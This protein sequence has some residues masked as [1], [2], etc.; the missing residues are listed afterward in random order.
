MFSI[1]RSASMTS[2][3]ILASVLPAAAAKPLIAGPVYPGIAHIVACKVVNIT[4]APLIVTIEIV[5]TSIGSVLVNTGP[6]T[7]APDHN[8]GTSQGGISSHVMC[9]FTGA[10]KTKVRAGLTIYTNSGDFTDEVFVP[11]Q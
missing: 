1:T 2:L 7:L 3:L 8:L 9:R 5:D 10:S 11:A 6:L 4:T